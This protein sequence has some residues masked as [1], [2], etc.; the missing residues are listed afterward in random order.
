MAKVRKLCWMMAVLVIGAQ[1]LQ[2][3][4]T[5][6]HDESVNGDLLSGGGITPFGTLATGVELTVIGSL[7]GGIAG[8]PLGPDEADVFSFTATDVWDLD[9]VS[10]SGQPL[11][12]FLFQF[13]SGS[14][15]A[16]S[17]PVPSGGGPIFSSQ[18]AGSY[19]INLVPQT[20][21]GTNDYELV[22]RVGPLNPVIPEPITA[23]LGL[24]GLGVLGMATRRRMA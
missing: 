4:P 14:F 10:V 3:V 15:I 19:R 17:N 9:S 11:V 1:S 5:V 7:D 22:F 12:G 6:L 24:M 18:P 2:A 13:P 23:T 20:N 16:A 21:Q 8:G